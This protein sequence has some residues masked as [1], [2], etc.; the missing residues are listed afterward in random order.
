MDVLYG[1]GADVLPSSEALRLKEAIEAE[2]ARADGLAAEN[3]ELRARLQAAE[4]QIRV[5]EHNISVL[6][7]TAKLELSRVRNRST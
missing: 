1:G 6:Y 4:D 3:A 7:N 5:L 2:R